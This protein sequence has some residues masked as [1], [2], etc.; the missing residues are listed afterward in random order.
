MRGRLSEDRIQPVVDRA[1]ATTEARLRKLVADQGALVGVEV[2]THVV[3]G[4][5]P[6]A[7]P[8][9]VQEARVDLLVMGTVGRT[10][11]KGLL[12]GNTAEEILAR[13]PGS[14]LAVKPPGFVS[15]VVAS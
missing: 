15:P 13:T 14:I 6:H 12:I 8:R 3:E 1:T 4:P 11:I 9:F 2:T 10:G 7:L 5:A